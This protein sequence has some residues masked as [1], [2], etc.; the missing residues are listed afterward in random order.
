M[1]KR[2]LITGLIFILLAVWAILGLPSFYFGF[3]LGLLVAIGAWEW[4]GLIGLALPLQRFFYSLL[5]LFCVWAVAA[6]LPVMA[7]LAAACLWWLVSLVWVM[8]FPAGRSLWANSLIGSLA[9]LFVLVPPWIAL[10]A[11]HEGDSRG[12]YFVL[13]LLV[14]IW[15]ADTAAYFAGRRWGSRRLAPQVSPGKTWEGLWGATLAVMFYALVS[16]MLVFTGAGVLTFML[17][18]LVTLWFSILGD[19]VESMFKR[20]AG[21]KDSG[22]LLPGHGGLLDRIDSLTAAAPVFVLSLLLSG[23]LK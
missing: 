17:L 9:G 8:R 11:L 18:C 13:F 22:R 19:L 23:M 12:P 4:A 7:V 15:L 3:A 5:V 6:Y 20:Q 2:R 16:G 10:M 14:M 21:V 1:L